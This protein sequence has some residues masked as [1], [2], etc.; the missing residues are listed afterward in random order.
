MDLR[1]LGLNGLVEPG[2]EL[3]DRIGIEVFLAQVGQTIVFTQLVDLH[4]VLS[5]DPGGLM[6]K[7]Q[8]WTAIFT[9]YE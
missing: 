4:L 6:R 1:D 3:P 2:Q 8:D 5:F 9:D 7:R